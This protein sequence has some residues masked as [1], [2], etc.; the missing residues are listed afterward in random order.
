MTTMNPTSRI[1]IAGY[2]GLHDP[3]YLFTLRTH[4]L[5][6][7]IGSP[8]RWGKVNPPPAFSSPAARLHRQHTCLEGEPWRLA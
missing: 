2:R 3:L 7:L 6:A 5:Y 4:L 1:Y 8:L